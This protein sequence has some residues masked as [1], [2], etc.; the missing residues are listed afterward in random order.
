MHD[1][2]SQVTL[3]QRVQ[4]L[5]E[6]ATRDALTQVA[7]RA[8][9]DRLLQSSVESHLE[10]RL[11]CSLIICDLDHFKRINDTFGH[12]AGDEV[13]VGFG[14]LLRRHCRSGDL[15]ARYGGEEFVMLCPDCDNATAT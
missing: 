5:H 13:L 6:R 4:S 9:F 7:N 10:R 8:E 11:P 14:A 3:E 1:A 15:V 12:P 2:S